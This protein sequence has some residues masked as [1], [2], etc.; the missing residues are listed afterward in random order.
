MADSIFSEMS[1]DCF[2]TRTTQIIDQPQTHINTK[3]IQIKIASPNNC[4]IQL[5]YSI[6]D[7]HGKNVNIN[8]EKLET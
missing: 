1:E 6:F 8:F 4:D 3:I 2:I 5:C 7:Y